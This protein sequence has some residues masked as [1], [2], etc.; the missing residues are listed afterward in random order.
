MRSNAAGSAQATLDLVRTRDGAGTSLGLT[1]TFTGGLQP[2]DFDGDGDIDAADLAALLNSWGP[3]T[4]CAADLDG[5]GQVDAA[6]LA[7]VLNGW[8]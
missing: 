2:G 5:N 4:G 8:G 1:G 6:D 7:G 3:C